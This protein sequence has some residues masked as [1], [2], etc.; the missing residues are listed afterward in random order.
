MRVQPGH[1]P[2][3]DRDTRFV[4]RDPWLRDHYRCESCG[5]LPRDR[6]FMAVLEEHYPG[7]RRLRI[8]ESSPGTAVSRRL[9]AE[10]RGY[11]ATHLFPGT[12]PGAVR[13][14]IRCEDLEAQTFP[15]GCF[16]LVVTLD[17]FEHV[18]DPETAFREIART[19]A[20]GGAHV[21]TTPRFPGLARSE[22]RARRVGGR[23]EHLLPP[24][25]HGNPID[26]QG[27]LVTVHWGD[28]IVDLIR[29]A[30]GMTTT[31]QVPE[32]AAR[33]IE[34]EFLDVFVSVKRGDATRPALTRFRERSKSVDFSE[35]Y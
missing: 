16:D 31:V 12:P 11:V 6:A 21:F 19:L 33:G 25:Y 5:S 2:V 30:S 17:V 1:C 27:S 32:D 9:H 20:P 7:W 18:L 4:A 22:F 23:V 35:E 34:G 10:C 15:D 26:P 28:D 29:G 13:N 3:C 14:G 24:E 8:H